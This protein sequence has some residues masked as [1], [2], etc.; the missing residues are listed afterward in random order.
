MFRELKI[1]ASNLHLF[2]KQIRKVCIISTVLLEHK[3]LG[4]VQ[5]HKSLLKTNLW[6]IAAN[7]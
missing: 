3:R 5:L 6:M 4:Q 7:I 1:D 2:F